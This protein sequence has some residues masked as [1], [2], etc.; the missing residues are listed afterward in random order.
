V[1]AACCFSTHDLPG[2]GKLTASFAKLP[3]KPPNSAQNPQILFLEQGL[4][5]ISCLHRKSYKHNDLQS[6]QLQMTT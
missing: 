2:T 1:D 6:N 3:F 4:T 5:G